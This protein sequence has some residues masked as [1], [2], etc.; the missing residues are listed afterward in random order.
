MRLSRAEVYVTHIIMVVVSFLIVFPML[1][2][3]LSSFKLPGDFFDSSLVFW[4]SEWSL[5]G[6]DTVLNS[7]I[8]F[9]T[10][11]QNG[12]L[13]A[14][15]QALGQLFVGVIAAYALARYRFPGR[16][17]LFLFVLS[18]IIIP[19]QAIM[20]PRFLVVNQLGW[21][22]TFH[23]VIVPNLASGFAIFF[24]R[25]FFLS[26]P[27][28]L[29]EAAQLDGCNELQI[30]R[31]VYLPQAFAP[32]AA[33]GVLSFVRAWNDYSWPLVVMLGDREK[34]PLTVALNF[35]TTDY[36]TDFVASMAVS[37]L[38]IIPV[39]LLYLF[40]QKQFVSGFAGS[41]LKG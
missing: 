35:F 23:G 36:N 12:L 40:A 7:E 28:E 22:Q 11:L 14:G 13:I 10:W 1:W 5:Q 17:I 24:M 25:Q 31:H 38:T 34:L 16:D 6:Y 19:E 20:V 2:M 29:S 8:P 4:P 39:L 15:L 27:S 37:T 18:T 30:L 26:V 32:I 33:L 21:T 3:L 41:G 9:R